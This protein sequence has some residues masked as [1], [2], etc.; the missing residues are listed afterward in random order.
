MDKRALA[1]SVMLTSFIEQLSSFIS[2][3]YVYLDSEGPRQNTA[4]EPVEIAQGIHRHEVGQIAEQKGKSRDGEKKENER[5]HMIRH[6]DLTE[7]L[8]YIRITEKK[9]E[10]LHG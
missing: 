6:T 4:R 8:R 5:F 9:Q 2:L 3:P 7:S 10:V 1:G